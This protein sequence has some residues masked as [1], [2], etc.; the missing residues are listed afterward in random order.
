MWIIVFGDILDCEW[1]G[2][3]SRWRDGCMGCEMECGYGYYG[4]I[5]GK[6]VMD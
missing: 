5:P 2:C 6:E 3:L 4:M 1:G